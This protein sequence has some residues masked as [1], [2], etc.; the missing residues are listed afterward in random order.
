LT[1]PGAVHTLSALR[2]KPPFLIDLTTE[3]RRR[4]PRIGDKS[5]RFVEQAL[6]VAEQNP[7]RPNHSAQ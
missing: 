1:F 2:Q 7:E 5:R 4:L 3:E 6:Q